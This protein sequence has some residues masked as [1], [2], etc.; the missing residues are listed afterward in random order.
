MPLRWWVIQCENENHSHSDLCTLFA[1][2]YDHIAVEV[3]LEEARIKEITAAANDHRTSQHNYA[4]L[5]ARHVNHG[6][7]VSLIVEIWVLDSV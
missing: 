3:V 7:L 4:Q 6:L 2:R 5:P 1:I